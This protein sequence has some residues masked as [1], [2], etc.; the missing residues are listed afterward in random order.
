LLIAHIANTNVDMY[1][2]KFLNRLKT[3]WRSRY[4]KKSKPGKRLY[5]FKKR[6]KIDFGGNCEQFVK[7]HHPLKFSYLYRGKPLWGEALLPFVDQA[8]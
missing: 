1:G 6:W 7:S 5:N 4:A 8:N 2:A 3:A